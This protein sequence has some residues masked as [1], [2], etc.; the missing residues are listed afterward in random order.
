M[1]SLRNA[2]AIVIAKCYR[3]RHCEMLPSSSLRNAAAIVIAKCCRD[4]HCEL[5]KQARQSIL[6]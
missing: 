3:D 4:R 1:R 5:A 6:D 2:A